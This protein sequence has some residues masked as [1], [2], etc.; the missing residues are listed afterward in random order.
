[1]SKLID[2]ANKIFKESGDCYGETII[3]I[4]WS[5]IFVGE[6]YMRVPGGWYVVA[7]MDQGSGFICFTTNNNGNI[8]AG[9]ETE[10]PKYI[11]SNDIL[12]EVVI[13]LMKQFAKHNII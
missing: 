1:M 9:W 7:K 6:K 5:T 8:V 3:S 13:E 10:Y 2:F 11:V 12:I 4:D